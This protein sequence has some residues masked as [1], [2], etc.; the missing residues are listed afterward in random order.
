MMY[1]LIPKSH[2]WL[3]N[4]HT[5]KLFH[6]SLLICREYDKY[7]QK[8]N[9][10][11]LNHILRTLIIYIIYN[12]KTWTMNVTMHKDQDEKDIAI[13]TMCSNP[14]IELS[15]WN[16]TCFCCKYCLTLYLLFNRKYH[17]QFY[18]TL[19]IMTIKHIYR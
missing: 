3:W 2:M 19:S 6:S 13:S 5:R 15:D 4:L 18:R 10:T 14:E 16:W 17:I 8:Y 12:I 7:T 11:Q 1:D 9:G